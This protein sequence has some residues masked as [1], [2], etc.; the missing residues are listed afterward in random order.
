MKPR[1]RAGAFRVSAGCCHISAAIA[2]V[3]R[4]GGGP[5]MRFPAREAPTWP[6]R[7]TASS[8]ASRAAHPAMIPLATLAVLIAIFA[9]ELA[10]LADG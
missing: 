3:A 2:V 7:K 10:W 4:R 5:V 1:P 8:A 6:G 9:L